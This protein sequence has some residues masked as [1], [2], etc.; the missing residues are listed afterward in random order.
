MGRRQENAAKEE[1]CCDLCYLFNMSNFPLGLA[2]EA[3]PLPLPTP[4]PLFLLSAL[5]SPLQSGVSALIISLQT[6]GSGSSGFNKED[7][8][9]VRLVKPPIESVFSSSTHAGRPNEQKEMFGRC[10]TELS[11]WKTTGG[12]RNEGATS[13]V[14]VS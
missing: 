7:V 1:E 6:A 12:D 5:A 11:L 9:L 14:S 8:L 4:P 10:K 3:P 2:D 13:V